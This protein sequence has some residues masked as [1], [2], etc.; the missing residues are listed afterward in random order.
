M[1]GDLV[2][3]LKELLERK[4]AFDG[5]IIETTGGAA[6]HVLCL[7]YQNHQYKLHVC[8]V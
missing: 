5:I 4:I 3:V 2:K 6:A 7:L 8:L 1:R